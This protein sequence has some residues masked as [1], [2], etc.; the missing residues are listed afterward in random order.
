MPVYKAPVEDVIFLLKD[1]LAYDRYGNLPGFSEAPIDMVEAIITEG[2][3]L[4]EE[5]FHP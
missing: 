4:C 1:V 5:V 2:A 3:K